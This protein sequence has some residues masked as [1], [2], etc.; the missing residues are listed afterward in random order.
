[1]QELLLV[2]KLM[3]MM[4]LNLMVLLLN[5]WLLVVML[6]KVENYMKIPFPLFFQF[7]MILCYNKFYEVVP[8]DAKENS[9]QFEYK[10]RFV[11]HDELFDD[12]SFLK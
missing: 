6:W 10:S 2:M 3:V 4:T 11:S 9:E 8:A 7:T 1:M 12:V 5:L